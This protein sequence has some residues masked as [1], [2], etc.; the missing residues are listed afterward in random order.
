MTGRFQTRPPLCCAGG[1]YES[2]YTAT[3]VD[4]KY[5]VPA[6]NVD[7]DVRIT[8]NFEDNGSEYKLVFGEEFDGE[9][10]SQPDSKYWSRSS[11]ENPTWK[12]FCAQT[13]AGQKETGWIEDGKLVLR[14]LK[15]THDGEKDGNGNK[16]QMCRGF[17]ES[18]KKVNFTHGKV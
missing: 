11:R 1:L 8:A 3:L 18:S 2:E 7:G 5:T 17:I 16:Q 12:R 9:N 15:N 6:E 10:G 13:E 4:G 14:C